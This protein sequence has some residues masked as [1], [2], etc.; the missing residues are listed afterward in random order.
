[1]AEEEILAL[2]NK[3]IVPGEELIFS[4]IGTNKV[5]WQ[6][7]LKT[8]SENHKN[9]TWGWNYYNDGKQWLFKVVQK[10]KTLFWGAIVVT[11]DFRLTFYFGDKAEPA[12]NGSDLPEKIREGFRTAKRYGAIRPISLI[13]KSDEDVEIILKLVDIKA[14]LK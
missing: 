6:H 11:G 12:I 4:I 10:K 7:I 14:S 1:M 8:I 3:T 13:V 9:V 5:Y 2:S